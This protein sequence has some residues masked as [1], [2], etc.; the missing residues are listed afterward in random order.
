MV[1]AVVEGLEHLGVEQTHQKIQTVV[2]VR[3]HRIQS[4][5]LLF[6]SVDIHIVM[7]HD[8]FD[9]GQIERSQPDGGGHENRL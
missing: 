3:Y 5:L 7:V 8:S 9:L 1:G 6:Q 4:T 2:V